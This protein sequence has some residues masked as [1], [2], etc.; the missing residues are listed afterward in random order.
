M[1]RYK[2]HHAGRIELFFIGLPPILWS[3]IST[4]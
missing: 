4:S 1:D 3:D 2:N